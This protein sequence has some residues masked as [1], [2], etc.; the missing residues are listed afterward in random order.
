MLI[1]KV[2][3]FML[4]PDS[5]VQADDLNV[6]SATLYQQ[7]YP[8]EGSALF[9]SQ[10]VSAKQEM[11][12]TLGSNNCSM[13]TDRSYLS[14]NLGVAAGTTGILAG[15]A[16][17]LFERVRVVSSRGIVLIDQQQQN[18]LEWV[19]GIN[20]LDDAQKACRWESLGDQINISDAN[21][22]VINTATAAVKVC[23]PLPG[24]FFTQVLNLCLPVTGQ[25][26]IIFTMAQDFQAFSLCGSTAF[27]YRVDSPS[28][29]ACLQPLTPDFQARMVALARSGGLLLNYSSEY[30]TRQ[31]ITATS[32]TVT[33]Q[34][35]LKS[36]RIV[37]VLP[38]LSSED[39]TYN[40]SY[41][42]GQS[43]A[44]GLVSFSCR[45]G[46]SIYPSTAL[47]TPE[48]VY[49]HL[50]QIYGL[51][52]DLDA[53]NQITRAGFTAAANTSVNQKQGSKWNMG[54]NLAKGGINTGHNTVDSPI[55][56]M[57][58]VGASTATLDAFIWITYDSIV[59]VKSPDQI[60]VDM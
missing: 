3:Q 52:G 5:I 7:F 32:N 47:T 51:Y 59:I 4:L 40:L 24:S 41:L 31:P 43:P 33:V 14:F 27:R 8:D 22:L 46:S 26:R 45:A 19:K 20:V 30:F 11:T 57:Y 21:S 49:V 15:D 54:V 55:Q 53:G 17:A 28:L 29:T 50:K 39:N 38:R 48:E 13:L 12:F 16:S 44:S 18:V 36:A 23:M 42:K 60:F 58:Q 37:T 25:I 34:R 35:A 1:E 56:I 9:G 10:A 2:N 6:Q